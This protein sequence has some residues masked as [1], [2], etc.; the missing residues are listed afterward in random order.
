MVFMIFN[1]LKTYYYTFD[2]E[3]ICFSL[4]ETDSLMFKFASK[5][6]YFSIYHKNYLGC[7]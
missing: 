7:Q 4:E 1:C 2:L 3:F 5:K 6:P